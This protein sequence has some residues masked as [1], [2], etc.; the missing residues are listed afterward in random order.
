MIV[1]RVQ[2]AAEA[3]CGALHRSDF[4]FIGESGP[5][6]WFVRGDEWGKRVRVEVQRS[7]LAPVVNVKIEWHNL[8]TPP[9]VLRFQQVCTVSCSSEFS[10]AKVE[11]A[12][13]SAV[14]RCL[15]VYRDVLGG[16]GVASADY[17][18]L[19]KLG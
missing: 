11:S 9:E 7:V 18:K 14:R 10:R 8:S 4:R 16:Q 3:I 2:E 1:T 12:T 19:S 17:V 6:T 13:I 5:S 15:E